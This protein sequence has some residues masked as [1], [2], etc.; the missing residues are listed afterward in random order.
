MVLLDTSIVDPN[1]AM[2]A[3]LV[4]FLTPPVI[5]IITR[6]IGSKQLQAITAFIFELLV[7]IPTAY[8]AAD[9]TVQ[10]YVKSALIVFTL[11]MVSYQSVWKPTGVTPSS[12]T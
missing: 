3:G 4:G 6:N 1:A 12:G 9:L 5:Q 7:A 10:D 8:F 11:A 2:W